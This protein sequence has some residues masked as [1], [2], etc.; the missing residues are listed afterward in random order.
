MFVA[1]RLLPHLHT[2]CIDQGL[3]GSSWTQHDELDEDDDYDGLVIGTYDAARLAACCS[4]LCALG[5]LIIT[6]DVTAADLL[7]L[8]QLS[9][10]TKLELGG[11]AVADDV[12]E[13]VLAN[14]TG[15]W[16]LQQLE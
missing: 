9:V 1:G 2:I 8:L 12:A 16:V 15:E 14:L 13:Q 11:K 6:D 3:F 5:T 7:P 10:L 4:G